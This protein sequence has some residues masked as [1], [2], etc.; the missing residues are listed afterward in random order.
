MPLRPSDAVRQS[1]LVLVSGSARARP[2]VVPAPTH[3]ERVSRRILA[4]PQLRYVALALKLG[5]TALHTPVQLADWRDRQGL[6]TCSA[7]DA[8]RLDVPT[9][10]ARL[11]THPSPIRTTMRALVKPTPGGVVGHVVIVSGRTTRARGRGSLSNRVW[12]S[13]WFLG[14]RADLLRSVNVMTHHHAPLRRVKDGAPD[15]PRPWRATAKATT[16]NS[17]TGRRMRPGLSTPFASDPEPAA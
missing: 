8:S 12:R 5:D 9:R 11:V 16:T 13:G 15:G 1:A 2:D 17:L 7:V 10:L 6:A 14:G 4:P 3:A